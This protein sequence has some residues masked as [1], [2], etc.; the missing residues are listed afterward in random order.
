MKKLIFIALLLFS[1]C[2]TGG[3]GIYHSV[4]E[5]ES[6]RSISKLYS[7]DES[8]I[9][10]ENNIPA[11]V[12]K[13]EKGSSVFIPGVSEAKKAVKKEKVAQ[14]KER[15]GE[16][17]IPSENKEQKTEVPFEP[18]WPVKGK[19]IT[20][21]GGALENRSEGIDI[22]VPEGTNVKA[23]ENGKV[24]FSASHSG[25]GNMIIIQHSQQFISIYAHLQ[26]NFAKEGQTV[27][28]G[29]NIGQSGKTGA[30]VTPKLHFEIREFSKP[31]DPEKFLK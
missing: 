2:I 29:D 3:F 28:K 30:T 9:R 15:S 25:F 14:K 20:K 26:A 4:G 1:S 18:I 19:I 10:T 11:D 21:F 22:E 6:V 23:I 31:V 16:E 5:N 12:E 27:E 13:L 8:A 7:V 24:I 17:V